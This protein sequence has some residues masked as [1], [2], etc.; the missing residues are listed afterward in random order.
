MLLVEEGNVLFPS[1]LS[2]SLPDDREPTDAIVHLL[3][4]MHAQDM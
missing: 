3:R 1:N 4:K 2:Q